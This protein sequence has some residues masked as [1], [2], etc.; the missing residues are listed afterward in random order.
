MN[1]TTTTPL[2]KFKGSEMKAFLSLKP[3][4]SWSSSGITQPKH[5]SFNKHLLSTHC[6]TDAG[7]A[8]MEDM[9]ASIIDVC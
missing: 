8:V 4:P 7:P 9:P 6:M 1:G 2:G 3:S 5:L